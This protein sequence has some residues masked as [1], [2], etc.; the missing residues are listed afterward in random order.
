MCD[1]QYRIYTPFIEISRRS[2]NITGS[3]TMSFTW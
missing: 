3:L 2:H 1:Y